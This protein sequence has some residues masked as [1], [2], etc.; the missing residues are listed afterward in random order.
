MLQEYIRQC[1]NCLSDF[2]AISSVWCNCDPKNPSKLC[3]F[4]LQCFCKAPEVYKTNFWQNAPSGLTAEQASLRNNKDRIGELLFRAQMVRAEELLSALNQQ[5][6]S[7]E[8]IGEI[9]VKNRLLTLEELDLFL[10]MQTYTIPHDFT[11]KRVDLDHLQALN[12]AFCLQRK[13]LPLKVFRSSNRAFL[14]LAAADL[15]DTDTFE[16]VNRK[17]GLNA[18]PFYAE[19]SAI[20]SFLKERVSGESS[21]VNI[22]ELEVQ[23]SIRK[24]IT[25]AIKKHASDI[26]IET[27]ENEVSARYR[28]DGVLYVVKPIEK[29]NQNLFISAIKKLANM[30]LSNSQFPQSSRLVMTRDDQRYQLNVLTF[31]TPYGENIT[32]KIVNLAAFQRG[33]HELGLDEYDYT[34][35]LL[36]LDSSFGLIVI[37][38]PVMNG[39]STTQYAMLRYLSASNRKV[40]TLESPIFTMIKNIH[41]TEINPAAGYDYVSVLN[42]IIRSDPDVIFLSDLPNAEV[43]TTVTK[44]ASRCVVVVALAADSAADT[45]VLLRELGASPSMLAHSLSLVANQRLIRKI[46]PHCSRKSAVSESVLDKMG[47]REGEVRKLESFTGAGCKECNYLGFQGRTAIFEVMTANQR[48]AE[49]ITAGAAAKEIEKTA[50][51]MGM[52]SLRSKCL[53]KVGQGITTIEE[54]EKCKFD[55]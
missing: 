40:M 8:K 23:A 51:R 48:I 28:I 17:T 13:I 27:G 16:I 47:F 14:V 34:R 2:D 38:G 6:V 26:H 45:I 43:A 30:D 4:C 19:P 24:M 37:S 33:L 36:A 41:Q 35:L 11:E 39:C 21:L 18:V 44:I 52:I 46:C 55:S 9:L 15:K 1:W 20:V 10:E 53:Q 7:G 25:D 29:R 12:P 5:A 22:E 49:L 31:P 32:I 3:P 42:S 54:F 50:V